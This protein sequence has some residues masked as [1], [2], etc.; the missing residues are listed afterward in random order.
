M[1]T[2]RTDVLGSETRSAAVTEARYE[3]WHHWPI[4][5]SAVWVGA[6]AALAVALLVGLIGVAVGAH[7]FGPEHRVVD[8]H[9]VKL[10]ALI[11]SV[12]GAFFA[13]VV[14]GW[15]AG[16][17]AGIL[18]AEEA[19]LHG[20]I[21]WLVATPLLLVLIGLGAGSFFGG[22]YAGLAGT[23]SWAAAASA[24]FDRPEPPGPAATADERAQYQ[25]DRAEYQQKVKQWKEDTPRATRNS[26]LGAV[27]ALLLGLVG[28]VIGGWMASGEPMSLTYRRTASRHPG[29]RVTV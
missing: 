4:N 6:L 10:T 5:W 14:G 2:A 23:P 19:M 27:T 22:W 7:M 24:P 26:A 29:A 12:C 8:L 15:V 17:I 28:S 16:K 20:A 21:A 25:A 18:H 13:F 3:G 11:F 9:K 1:I